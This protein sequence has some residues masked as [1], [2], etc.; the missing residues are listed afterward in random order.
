MGATYY[1]IGPLERFPDS[2]IRRVFLNGHEIAV[3]LYKGRIYAFSNR[4]T[5]NDFQMHFGYIEDDCLWCPIHYGQYDLA[6]GRAI[7]GPITDLKSYEV[8]IVGD[9]VQIGVPDTETPVG[10]SPSEEG[11]NQ[12]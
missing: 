12:G 11:S 2:K 10:S 3:V 4:C 7:S 6:S 9:E 5:H 8:R 1:S